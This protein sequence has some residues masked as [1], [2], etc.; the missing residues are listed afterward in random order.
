[1]SQKEMKAI[2]NSLLSTSDLEDMFPTLSG[3]WEKDKTQFKKLYEENQSLLDF[4]DNGE[5]D[6]FFLHGGIEIE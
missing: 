5:D 4:S 3:V 2:Y 1:M 6:D